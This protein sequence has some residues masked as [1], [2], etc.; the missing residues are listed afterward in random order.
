MQ[1]HGPGPRTIGPVAEDGAGMLRV[2]PELPFAGW[3]EVS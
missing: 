3:V 1:K 2:F